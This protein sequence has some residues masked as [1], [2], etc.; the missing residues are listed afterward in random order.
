MFRI[1]PPAAAL[2]LA[3]LALPAAASAGVD[4]SVKA[5]ASAV[6]GAGKAAQLVDRSAAAAREAVARSQASM[7][8]AYTLTV[9]HGRDASAQGM[10]AAVR[11]SAAAEAQGEQLQSVIDGS[12]G[13]VKAAAAQALARTGTWEARVVGVAAQD[14]QR[15][16]DEQ[17]AQL[18][19]TQSGVA[20]SLVA[21]A[22]SE[23]LR[24]SARRTL[25]VATARGLKAL[26]ALAAAVK[27]RGDAQ[28]QSAMHDAGLQVTQAVRGSG[29]ADLTF[30][31]GGGTVTLGQLALRTMDT[32]ASP[33]QASASGEAHVVVGGGARR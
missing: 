15:G 33:A 9:R 4:A 17:A 3:A 30:S 14:L 16:Q 28:A 29:R 12:R 27:R 26:S 1:T 6:A 18:G 23:G 25:D 22:S 2:T 31:V 21:G 13:R 7:R 24:R 8:R 32:S 11:F 5:E 19:D 20:V 10:Q